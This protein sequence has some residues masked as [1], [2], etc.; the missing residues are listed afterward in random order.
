MP[1]AKSKA[2]CEAP[3]RASASNILITKKIVITKTIMGIRAIYHAG[4]SSLLN[5][6]ISQVSQKGT[7]YRPKGLTYR[8]VRF[9]FGA[10]LAIYLEFIGN[11]L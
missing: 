7:Y 6:F 11:I 8:D 2:T 9:I 1:E 4:F 5:S 3:E 10:N